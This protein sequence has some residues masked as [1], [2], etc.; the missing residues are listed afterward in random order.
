MDSTAIT[1]ATYFEPATHR[2]SVREVPRDETTRAIEPEGF[3]Q[4]APWQPRTNAH[5]GVEELAWF[6]EHQGELAGFA[7]RWIAVVGQQV[8]ASA[9]TFSE[10]YDEACRL[11]H[12]DMLILPVP[13]HP[14]EDRYFIA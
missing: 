12:S 10:A 1:P 5:A 2:Y 7:G 4:D 14:G 13:R 11:N 9:D 6:E 8:I 3:T